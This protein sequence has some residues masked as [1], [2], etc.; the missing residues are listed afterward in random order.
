MDDRA[1]PEGEVHELTV[2]KDLLDD[3]NAAKEEVRLFLPF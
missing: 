2:R 1:A 3:S